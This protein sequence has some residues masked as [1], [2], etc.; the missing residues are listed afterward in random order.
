MLTVLAVVVLV[1]F[2]PERLV[3]FWRW[4]PYVIGPI[5]VIPMIAVDITRRDAVWLRIERYVT[6]FFVAFLGVVAIVNL[7]NLISAMVRRPDDITGLQL[8]T[9]SIS[10]YVNNIVVFSLLYWQMDRGGPEARQ[11]NRENRPD[12]LFPQTGVPDEAPI[13]WRPTYVDYLFLAFSTATAFSTTEVS[14]MTSRAKLLMMLE[15]TIALVTLVI[16]ASRAINILGS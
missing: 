16:V 5:V 12:W 9:S 8:L 1:A 11:N 4:S 6:L 10:V 7:S 2:L 13:G 3:V 14:P 15:A